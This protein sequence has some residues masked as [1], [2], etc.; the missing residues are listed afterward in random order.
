MK[1]DIG[2]EEK[3]IIFK[4]VEIVFDN[5]LDA[6]AEEWLRMMPHFCLGNILVDTYSGLNSAPPPKFVSTQNLRM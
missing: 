3:E 6:K 5:Y 2:D 4:G 1:I